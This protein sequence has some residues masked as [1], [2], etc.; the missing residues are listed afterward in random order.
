M[1]QEDM[2]NK[3]KDLKLV[4]NDEKSGNFKNHFNSSNFKQVT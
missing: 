2:T 4:Y 1:R 3:T